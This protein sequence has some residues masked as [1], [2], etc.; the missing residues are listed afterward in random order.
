MSMKHGF[1]CR[2]LLVEDDA[3]D[4]HL[5]H[6]LLKRV[7]DATFT[8]AWVKSLAEARDHL[9]ADCPD[10]VL[11]DLTLP[12][13]SGLQTVHAGR[14]A[15]GMLPLI[16]LTGHDDADFALQTLEAGAQ[17]YLIKGAF[18]ADDLVRAIRYAMS[19][20]K[21]EQR[22]SEAEER[23]RFALEGAGDGVWDWDVLTGKVK[24]SRCFKAMLGY[25]EDEMKDSLDEWTTRIHPDDF[26]QVMSEVQAY[27]DG[28]STTYAKEH[29]LRCKNGK[30]K[31]VL[32]RG[33]VVSRDAD[34]KP[35]RMI[36][37]HTDIDM[38]KQA[39]ELSRLSNTVFNTVD[40]ALLVT[41]ADNRIV[42][43]NPSFTRVTGY[44]LEEV[45]GRNP[46]VLSS[47]RHGQD[48]YR[49]LWAKLDSEGGWSGELWNRRKNG[50]AYVEWASIKRVTDAHGKPTHYVAAFSDITV[51][52]ANEENIRHQAQYDAL[53]D[54]PNRVLLFDRLQQALA[55]A[56][57]EQ[58]HL[59][60]MYVD[61]DKFKQINDSLGH[62]IGDEVLQRVA[63][64]MQACVRE[65]D[66]VARIGGDEFVVLL[67]VIENEEDALIV[68]E[69]IRHLLNQPFDIAGQHL[70]IS[71]SIGIAIYPDHGTTEDEITANADIAMYLAKEAGR[72]TV[73]LFRHG[74]RVCD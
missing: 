11:L 9:K 34:G 58:S 4:A 61:L 50:E 2:I 67:P 6:Q 19:R 53:T 37:T 30:W 24:F 49:Q 1:S 18:E 29:R 21:L 22:L 13:S 60:L 51:R 44:T 38:L 66:T 64:R 10:V 46:S 20:A 14:A 47:G 48:F 36:G 3:S 42:M 56:K 7:S 70:E 41:D 27:L 63:D 55:Q 39:E 8:V 17:D 57:R 45:S 59:A 68:A 23:W 43:V 32:D 52:K 16:V 71:S 73:K 72:D 12:D 62:A 65:V 69:K 74:M 28:R 25:G 54:L 15:A 33:K 31:W 40:E 26:E 35:L 5:F